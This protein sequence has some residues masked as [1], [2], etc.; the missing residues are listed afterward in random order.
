MGLKGIQMTL[1]ANKTKQETIISS[2][3]IKEHLTGLY[4]MQVP[5]SFYIDNK[6]E[7]PESCLIYDEDMENALVV[8]TRAVRILGFTNVEFSYSSFSKSCHFFS[9]II[10]QKEVSRYHSLIRVEMP[11]SISCLEQRRYFRVR[12]LYD[13]Q[14]KFSLEET[15]DIKVTVLNLSGGGLSF[16]IPNHIKSIEEGMT[17]RLTLQLPGEEALQV[18]TLVVNLSQQMNLRRVGVE[19]FDIPASNRAMVLRYVLNKQREGENPGRKPQNDPKKKPK[20]ILLK[21]T[22]NPRYNFLNET[23]AVKT[24]KNPEDKQAIIQWNPDIAVLDLENPETFQHLDPLKKIQAKQFF[25]ILIVGT[26]PKGLD[27]TTESIRY[28]P[29]PFKER[30]VRQIIEQLFQQYHLCKKI[31]EKDW[32]KFKRNQKTILILDSFK[33]LDT[34]YIDYLKRLGLHVLILEGEEDLLARAVNCRPDLILMH[35]QFEKTDL[36][37]LCKLM[38]FKKALKNIPK[39]LVADDVQNPAE[40]TARNAISD[41]LIQ[42]FPKEELINKIDALL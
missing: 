26:D 6:V 29:P 16:L 32:R 13:V 31:E 5:V 27:I 9:K 22:D 21:D 35:E 28:S 23:F 20:L 19:F 14:A 11:E 1:E 36:I 24:L 33:N 3:A 10:S 15:A 8:K 39:L 7:L 42:P 12:A 38:S 17:L 41:I 40:L 2:E 18:D 25:P 30:F 37:S 4:H 34:A